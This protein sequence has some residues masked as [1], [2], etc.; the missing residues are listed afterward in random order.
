MG[1][2]PLPV[3]IV[4]VAAGAE[5][6]APQLIALLRGGRFVRASLREGCEMVEPLHDRVRE[7]IVAHLSPET[8]RAHHAAARPPAR[9]V[10]GRGPRSHR[11]A[12]G[13]GRATRPA[14]RSTP[15]APPSRPSTSWRSR[16][17]P[18][19]F[20][21][22]STPRRTDVARAY[23]PR[24]PRRRRPPSGRGTRTRPRARTSSQPSGRPPSSGSISSAPRPPSSS[25][26]VASRRAASS[27]G[28]SWR[29]SVGASPTPRS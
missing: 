16:R 26:P 17:R 3:S 25:R 15:S 24:A 6:L 22:R 18:A 13:R 23:P 21:G 29:R 2:R 10:A 7:T 19:S 9:G 20:S 11:H 4:G 1:G 14:R 27:D 28:A 8:A 5:A 12:P